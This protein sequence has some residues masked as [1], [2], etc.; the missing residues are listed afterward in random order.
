M[1]FYYCFLPWFVCKPLRKGLSFLQLLPTQNFFALFYVFS[2]FVFHKSKKE[3]NFNLHWK[4]LHGSPLFS[5]LLLN[6]VTT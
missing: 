4:V 2:A 3:N 5:P 1:P 6:D